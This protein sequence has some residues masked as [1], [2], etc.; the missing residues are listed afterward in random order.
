MDTDTAVEPSLFLLPLFC[1]H[2]RSSLTSQEQLHIP[3]LCLDFSLDFF[4]I[5]L[6]PSSASTMTV[7][8][9]CDKVLLQSC[10]KKGP[11]NSMLVR[12]ASYTHRCRSINT[13]RYTIAQF[14]HLLKPGWRHSVGCAAC[15]RCTWNTRGSAD[16]RPLTYGLAIA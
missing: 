11:R 3:I 6:G 12:T 7:E 10:F 15:F 14:L 16:S 13:C 4:E 5:R 8:F 9:R 1:D 2:Q